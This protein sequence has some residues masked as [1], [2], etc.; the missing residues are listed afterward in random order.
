MRIILLEKVENLGLIGD[1]IDVK[2]GYARNFLL[3]K[4][5][6]L[7][8]TDAN[9]EYFNG[10]KAELEATNLKLKADAEKVA[11][12]MQNISIV[13]VRQASESGFLFGS[14]RANDIVDALKEQGY[15]VTKSQVKVNNPIK[16]VGNYSIDIWLH[17]EVLVVISLRVI[18]AQEQGAV[19]IQETNQNNEEHA[20]SVGA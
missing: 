3:P 7:R 2:V 6:A 18:T 15:T 13:I 20:T 1:I 11:Q 9:I 14:V 16:M 8:A 4:K 12:K 17:P 10:K 19:E 5:K